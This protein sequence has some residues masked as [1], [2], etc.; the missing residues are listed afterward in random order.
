MDTTQNPI[1][2]PGWAAMVAEHPTRALTLQALTNQDLAYFTGQTDKR[3]TRKTILDE[4]IQAGGGL[5]ETSLQTIQR[6]LDALA[7]QGHVIKSS[8]KNSVS[9]WRSAYVRMRRGHHE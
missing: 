7:H 2:V 3:P 9:P 1:A 6:H 5:S 8:R 4:V